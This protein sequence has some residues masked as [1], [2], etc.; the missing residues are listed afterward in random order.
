MN[1]AR[2]HI[3]INSLTHQVMGKPMS[4]TL[5][6]TMAAQTNSLMRT[7]VYV[8]APAGWEGVGLK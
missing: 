1:T 7:T 6:R 4:E 3:V 2:T 5:A 8:V